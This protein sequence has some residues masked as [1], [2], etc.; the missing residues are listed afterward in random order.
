MIY[1]GKAGFAKSHPFNASKPVFSNLKPLPKGKV[2][3]CKHIAVLFSETDSDVS[4]G[5]INTSS[6]ESSPV[7][8]QPEDPTEAIV[9]EYG[10][11]ILRNLLKQEAS[12]QNGLERHEIKGKHRKQMVEWMKEVLRVFKSPKECFYTAV[13]IMDRYL[14]EKKQCIELEQLHEIGVASIFIASKYTELEPLTLDLM[15]R[16]ASHGKITEK[17]I[18]AREMDILNTLK[19]KISV[20]TAYECVTDFFAV[21]KQRTTNLKSIEKEVMERSEEYLYIA[22]LNFRFSFSMKPS[23][24]ALCIL[25]LSLLEALALKPELESVRTTIEDLKKHHVYSR[26]R[27]NGIEKRLVQCMEN[28]E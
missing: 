14:D 4:K 23:Q 3:K 24:L 1:N 28:S 5:T 18:L 10:D 7:K 8:K 2:K 20:P 26:G 6:E 11:S 21:M 19:F 22:S 12:N 16:K 15:Q 17:Q 13:M 25:K 27:M 9:A